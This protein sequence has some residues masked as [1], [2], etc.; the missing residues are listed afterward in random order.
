MSGLAIANTERALAREAN[1][2]TSELWG[3]LQGCRGQGV[4][5]WSLVEDAVALLSAVE[6]R[7]ARRRDEAAHYQTLA[8]TDPL[9]GLLNR[10]GFD[11][12]MRRVLAAASR[13][14]ETGLVLFVD[15][16]DFKRTNDELGHAG[17]DAV[18]RHVASMLTD[19]VR[20]TDVVARLGGDEF[21]VVLTKT[22]AEEAESR[23]RRLAVLLNNAEMAV[24]DR[25][26]T[27]RASFGGAAYGPGDT[28]AGI[29][30][31]ADAAM[32][33]NKPSRMHERLATG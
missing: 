24:A 17:G 23:A 11:E 26:V 4:D 22:G 5:A 32:Y 31:H 16:D 27:V 1:R 30:C 2:L 14:D 19:N 33:A 10:R 7:L 13:H 12:Q 29:L 9:I 21:V 28:A 18:L 3:R 6:H 8:T 20:E 15:L 25:I